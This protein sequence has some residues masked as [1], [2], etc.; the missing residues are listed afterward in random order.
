MLYTTLFAA[1]LAFLLKGS[2]SQNNRITYDEFLKEFLYRG[3]VQEI[4]LTEKGRIY[5]TIRDGREKGEMITQTSRVRTA[6]TT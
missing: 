3:N 5:V 1:T 6:R 4:T 2:S